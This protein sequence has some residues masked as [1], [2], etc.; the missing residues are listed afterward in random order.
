MSSL[1]DRVVAHHVGG[2]GFGVALNCPPGLAN[3]LVHVL[4]EADEKCANDM[5]AQNKAEN[6]HVLPYCLGVKN[7]PG[8]IFITKNPYAS[9]NFEPSKDYAEYYCELHLTGEVEGVMLQN[10]VYDAVY[11]NEN[12]VDEVRDVTIRT[13]DSILDS[14]AALGSL[15]PD[16]LSLDTQGSELNILKGGERV[17]HNHCVALATEIEFHPMYRDQ[18]LFSDIFDFALKHG[19]HFVGFT[20]L[21]EIS[22][23]RLPIGARAKGVLA[24]GDAL[25]FRNID[26][27][28]SIA[29]SQND[30]FL[31][32]LKLAFISLNFGYLE[33]ALQALEAADQAK[34]D[35]ELRQ[36][37]LERKC[38]RLLYDLQKAVKELPQHFPHF[39]RSKMIAE[40]K[41]ILDR[42]AEQSTPPTTSE[43]T[44]KQAPSGENVGQHQRIRHLIFSNPPAAIARLYQHFFGSQP[45]LTPGADNKSNIPSVPNHALTGHTTV[46]VVLESYGYH[47]LADVVRQRRR[48]SEHCVPGLMF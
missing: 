6:F 21:Q 12:K 18:A 26:S 14:D 45:A 11:G 43:P 22:P 7:Q 10:A 29:T 37:V 8:K 15:N 24:F 13:L 17:F 41:A 27:V 16:F 2:R 40:R 46:E 19:F 9:S 33:Y 47:W 34:P 32:L 36:K 42:A 35:N 20:Y 5:I 48:S 44:K 39:D 25:F 31:K 4:Y 38:F 28:R 30:L 3:D 1:E 23:N